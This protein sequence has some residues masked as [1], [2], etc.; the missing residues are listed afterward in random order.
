VISFPSKPAVLSD[1][2]RRRGLNLILA[3]TAMVACYEPTFAAEPTWVGQRVM[4]KETARPQ[5]AGRQYEWSSV[6]MPATVKQVNGPWFWLGSVWVRYD[7]VVPLADAPAYYTQL[8]QRDPTSSGPY[9]LRGVSWYAKSEFENAWKDFNEALRIDPGNSSYVT[10]RGK[11]N[12]ERHQY[13]AAVADFTEAIRLD[14]SN[15]VA[16]NDR[17]ATWKAK[18]EYKLAEGDLN[19]AI[20]QSPNNGTAYSNRGANWAAQEDYTRALADLN[21]AVQLS[22]SD[23]PVYLNRGNV[24]MKMGNYPDALPD[25]DE[26]IRLAPQ[27]WE[28]YYGWAKIL[29]TAPWSQMR[30]GKRAKTMAEKACELSKWRQWKAI[31]ALAAAYA[32]LDDFE[33]AIKWQTKAMA[34]SQP[35]EERDQKENTERLKAYQAGK[36]YYMKTLDEPN[37]GQ[38]A[39]ESDKAPPGTVK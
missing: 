14:P 4:L 24:L 34:L 26:A 18:G 16:Y 3:L 39:L 10:L 33:A 1:E 25:F 36:P 8:I 32:E 15:V 27:Q 12:Y 22:P 29:G 13:D 2:S 31:A 19:E 35:A 5:A 23:A 20:R 17:G 6:A 37:G 30:D 7:E 21:K 11:S 9:A 28:G 38:T